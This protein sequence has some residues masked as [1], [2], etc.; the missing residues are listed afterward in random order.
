M[1]KYT[2][3]IDFGTL[4]GRAVLMDVESGEIAATSVCE[5]KHGVIDRELPSGK[6]LP[7]RTALQDASD[8]TE[9]LSTTLRAVMAEVKADPCQVVG[10]GIDFTGC[11]MLPVDENMRPLMF[12]E[13]YKDEPHAYVKLWK[14]NSATKEGD[15][16]NSLAAE[17]GEKWLYAHGGKTSAEW[18]FAKILQIQREAPEI[19]ERTHLF[20]NSADWVTYLLTGEITHSVNIAE[21]KELWSEEDGFP[22]REFFEKLC[23]EMKDI[24]GTKIPDNMVYVSSAA[25]YISEEGARLTGLPVGIPMA[26]PVLDA[27]A[28]MPALGLTED[29]T[30]MM[31]LGT[32]AVHLVHCKEKRNIGGI[33]GYVTEGVMNGLY[34]YEAC[35]ACCGDHLD[36]YIRNALPA[37]YTEAAKAEGIGIHKYLREKAKKLRVGENGLIYLDWQNGNRSILTDLDLTGALFG[38]T[39]QTRPEEIYR[40]M[41]E[42][43]VFGAKVIL[44]NF[45]ANGIRI[46]K[47]VASGGIAE[48]DDMFMQICADVFGREIVV[49]DVKLSASKGSAI[50]AAVAAGIYKDVIEASDALGVRSGRL[51]EPIPENTEAYGRLYA[52]YLKLHDY[53]GRGGNDV[54]KRLKNI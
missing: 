6:R 45:E 12:D 36:W 42:G 39:L 7:P 22:S 29:G 9:V 30:L 25:G 38:L 52:E 53:F 37:S 17:R 51:Y 27:H 54:L 48:K 15:D 46:N 21:A 23:P 19:Y 3:G 35:Q 49:S 32:S 5:Y 4:S 24:I 34:T 16:I 44:D 2:V 50:Y 8:Y 31:I 1:K 40:A 33:F 11:T 14:H 43:T 18:M 20:L 28:S 10:I 41:I 26:T 13:K 47:I